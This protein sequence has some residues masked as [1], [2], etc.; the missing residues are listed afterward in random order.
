M[1]G[2]PAE[3]G[4]VLHAGQHSPG[5]RLVELHPDLSVGPESEPGEQ[6]VLYLFDLQ[7]VRA[8]RADADDDVDA[9][10]VL[11]DL[12]P[13]EVGT[14]AQLVLSA[15]LG[16]DT[17]HLG[18]GQH[19]VGREPEPLVEDLRAL[20]RSFPADDQLDDSRTRPG[21]RVHGNVARLRQR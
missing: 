19:D 7:L 17:A 9:R 15:E 8:L 1:P 10:V 18:R 6:V 5:R 12:D 21:G 4:D 16:Q 11:L 3:A 14:L 13:G 2:L 20:D